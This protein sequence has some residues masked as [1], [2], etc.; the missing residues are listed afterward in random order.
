MAKPTKKSRHDRN[1]AR[2]LGNLDSMHV[3]MPHMFPRRTD[4][5]AVLGEV[6][7]ITAINDYLAKK[8]AENP[9]FKYTWFHVIAA[10]IGKVM[11]LRPKMNWFISG[12]RYYERNQIILA[13]MVKRTFEDESEEAIAKCIIDPNGI[14]P[15]EQV[16]DYV[17]KFTHMVR[18]ENKTDSAT[19]KMEILKKLPGWALKL[20]FGV[21]RR[22]EYHG[23]Y[24]KAF[25]T[26]DPTYS[27]VYISNLGSIKMNA[28]YHHLYEWG[29]VSFFT[30][31]SEKKKLPV[32]NEDGTYTLHDTIKL[33]LTIDERIA[34]GYYFAGSLRLLRHLLQH[35]DLLD[36]DA[37]TPVEY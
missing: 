36:L 34:D 3:M 29:T 11:I 10:A 15:L 17:Q 4:N 13:F 7:D 22:L 32:F 19:D 1:D 26:D 31:I 37:N 16:H 9:E 21:L 23:M 25:T 33:G 20:F 6:V 24:P 27:S 18:K 12:R 8:N 14:S 35:P 28:D 2:W 5:E 30:V